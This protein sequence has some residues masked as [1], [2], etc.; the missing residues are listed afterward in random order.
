MTNR[1]V[2]EVSNEL[3]KIYSMKSSVRLQTDVPMMS[4]DSDPWRGKLWTEVAG[5]VARG[6]QGSVNINTWWGGF[7]SPTPSP[8]QD[9]GVFLA[10][11]FV[12]CDRSKQVEDW[13]LRL[14]TEWVLNEW[15]TN[16]SIEERLE[17]SYTACYSSSFCDDSRDIRIITWGSNP[18]SGYPRINIY[19]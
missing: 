14:S 11:P 9:Y 5:I 8:K 13:A 15:N 16:L 18:L 17:D 7:H 3:L 4:M 2:T 12:I 1:E 19:L 10:T 6:C